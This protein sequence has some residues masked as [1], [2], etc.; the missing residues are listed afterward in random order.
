VIL[1]LVRH[2]GVFPI[3]ALALACG[4]DSPDLPR[5]DPVPSLPT[6]APEV[7]PADAPAPPPAPATPME[8]ARAALG[9]FAS[10]DFQGL[11][12]L[13]HPVKGLHFSPSAFVD[14]AEGVVLT[15][16]EVSELGTDRSVRDWGWFDGSGEPIRSD[17]AEY[18][19]LFVRADEFL[20]APRVGSEG[21]IGVSTTVDN[22]AALF[23]G[24]ETVEFHL[25]GTDPDFEGMDWSSLRL[26]FLPM[27]S[28]WRLVA[29][30]HDRW[31]I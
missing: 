2:V 11:A 26:V 12:A 30:V 13:V 3:L 14:R 15:P 6:P 10:G 16:E 27:D 7:P 24:A 21:R 31:S 4:S 18:S 22:I 20:E 17:F 25:P 1:R 19:A 28:R 23:P 9:L 8:A 29:V 5:A